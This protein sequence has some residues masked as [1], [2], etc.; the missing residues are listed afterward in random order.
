M[1]LASIISDFKN[2]FSGITNLFGGSASETKY[3]SSIGPEGL[4]I[5]SVTNRPE[6]ADKS[7]QSSRGYAFE[8]GRYDNN[9]KFTKEAGWNEFRLQ[10]NPQELSQDEIFAIQVT[11]TLRGVL[12][13]H[14]GTIL[15][16]IMISG[17][18]G[19]SPL[20]REGGADANSGNPIMAS[21]HSGFQEFHEL[22]SYFRVYV[23]AKRL[24]GR[25]NG[26][27]RMVFKNFK[28]NEFLF[29][30]PQKFS[31]KRSAS[32]PMM[33]DYAISLKG[34]GVSTNINNGSD[35]SNSFLKDVDNVLGRAQAYL[36]L[37]VQVING[38][39]GA[40][41]RFERDIVNTVLN[42]LRSVNTALVAVR[43]G[44]AVFFGEFGITR[45]TIDALKTEVE[46]VEANFSDAIGRDMTSFNHATGRTATLSGTPGRQSTFQELQVMNG[47]S[48]AKK[49]LLLI[50][51][52]Q[53]KVF[54]KNVFETNLQVANNTGGK[55]TFSN[56]NSVREIEI[57]V[58][59]DLQTIA[60]RE[61][62]DVDKFRDI[63]ILNN[64]KPPYIDVAGGSGILKPGQK[65][66]LP[67]NAQ[68]VGSG[69]VKNK[70]YPITSAMREAERSLGVDL[71]LTADG[72]IAIS[73]TK[74]FDL[75]AGIENLSQALGVRIFLEK[76]SLKRHTHIGT[77]LQV[78]KKVRTS[79]LNE[80]K[81][82]IVSSLTS[83][84]RVASLPFVQTIQEGGTTT[85]NLVVQP[86][87]AAQP[88]PI[89]I[90]VN[91]G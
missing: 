41:R 57:L 29:V 38:S 69:A 64:L 21:G 23:E 85:I 34:I 89:P 16:D 51:S 22:R 76:G 86:K 37:S 79:L 50:A 80:L 52:L 59:D 87:I 5:K 6:Y 62:G 55:Y 11:P 49:G 42:P 71:K 77:N 73:P 43:G 83:D 15:K 88:I 28:D 39:V 20:R 35:D 60:A 40:I 36:D 67:Q 1:A 7:W 48:A 25:D 14:H 24:D 13:E 75:V 66:L 8:V 45:R 82:D 32:R 44:R 78:G 10:I 70:I 2:A 33:Y 17:T 84:S 46:S 19:I 27:L 68:N 26:E 65:I 18:T 47:F 31:M 58:G 91:N 12:V 63:A 90:R 3:P 9:G 72:D 61:F 53:D 54:E 74:D 4:E 81:S 56:P 30:E